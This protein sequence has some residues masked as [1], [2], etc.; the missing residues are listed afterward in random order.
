MSSGML[1]HDLKREKEK[2][3]SLILRLEAKDC[4]ELSDLDFYDSTTRGVEKRLRSLRR[5]YFEKNSRMPRVN[6][7]QKN[8]PE[9][10]NDET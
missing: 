10:I 6:R 4:L 2:L 5:F 8:N 7:T 1:I 9:E 3:E